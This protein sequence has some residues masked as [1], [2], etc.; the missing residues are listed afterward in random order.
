MIRCV[1]LIEMSCP[2]MRP[3][4]LDVQAPHVRAVIYTNGLYPKM[5]EAHA[6]THLYI[7]RRYNVDTH[8]DPRMCAVCMLCCVTGTA[9][10][11]TPS[12]QHEFT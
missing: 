10:H 9:A 12:K 4:K 1:I 8:E 7:T 11:A 3:S 2:L 6:E 5:Q